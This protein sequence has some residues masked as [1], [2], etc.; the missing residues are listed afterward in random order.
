MAKAGC[1]HNAHDSVRT[2]LAALQQLSSALPGQTLLTLFQSTTAGLDWRDVTWL[3]V[4]M[5]GF[6]LLERWHEAFE[7][8]EKGCD[9]S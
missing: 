2:T 5:Y 1:H 9:L 7:A 8:L 4:N 6:P 3:A